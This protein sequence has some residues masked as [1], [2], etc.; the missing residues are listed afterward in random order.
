MLK[1]KFIPL[2]IICLL[3]LPNKLTAQQ[4]I[5]ANESLKFIGTSSE[6][7][8]VNPS[9]SIN[10]YSSTQQFTISAWIK[11]DSLN[12]ENMIVFKQ[13][14]QCVDDYVFEINNNN[15]LKLGYNGGCQ[16]DVSLLSSSNSFALNQWY[17]VACVL[18]GTAGHRI[19]R[20]FINGNLVGS[21]AM[22]SFNP[23]ADNIPL[24]IGDNRQ[25]N[26]INQLSFS[27]DICEV[28]YYNIALTQSQIQNRM[29]RTLNLA[30][31]D[32]VGLI[33]YWQLNGNANDLS[34]YNNS[35]TID[36]SSYFVN[37]YPFLSTNVKPTVITNAPNS[38]Y[39]YQ[40]YPNPFNPSTVIR[41]ALTFN[42]NVKIELYNILGEKVK[43]LVN[44]E[45]EAGS[46]ELSFN[47]T[48]LASG[49]YF[50]LIEAK[51]IDG[52]SEFRDVKKMVLL[53]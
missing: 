30:S 43:E 22:A 32:S 44:G 35:G 12:K 27:G 6:G 9:S 19:M 45:K 49:V 40:N 46:H 34:K 39:L 28:Q 29:N 21:M 41:Y 18:D 8:V 48:G 36:G 47:T 3:F 15:S 17:H 31:S 33:G 25:W 2:F 52:K 5:N 50:Y 42:S 38:Y 51:S 14:G 1:T 16:G 20:I 11:L 53:K 23:L 10:S 26:G 37:E 7:V 24:V 4:N 13:Q